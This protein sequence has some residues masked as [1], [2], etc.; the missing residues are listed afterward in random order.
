MSYRYDN[1]TKKQ[2][3]A[4]IKTNHIIEAE[5]A[6]RLCLYHYN[7]TGKWP[8]LDPM[9][10]FTGSFLE[11]KHV[12]VGA[13]FKINKTPVDITQ[14]S[15]ECLRYFHEK[16]TKTKL[17]A[18][19]AFSIV[20]MNGIKIFEKPKFIIISP[21]QMQIVMKKS[22]KKYGLVKMPTKK[23]IVNK[24]AYRFDISMFE[25]NWLELPSLN[26]IKLPK[27]YKEIEKVANE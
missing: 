7:I 14:S 18:G 22:I 16:E 15:S 4:S 9:N 27:Q 10:E 8:S 25:D 5:I 2:F 13:D 23:T 6:L 17:C 26:G 24:K 19:G 1:R 11:N 20:F 12:K 3:K 21:K